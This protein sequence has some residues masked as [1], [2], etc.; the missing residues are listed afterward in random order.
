[1]MT[2]NPQARN[3]LLNKIFIDGKGEGCD[4]EWNTFKSYSFPVRD[5]FVKTL[6]IAYKR[7]VAAVTESVLKI[8]NLYFETDEDNIQLHNRN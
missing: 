1:M 7:E 6:L 5:A 4:K 2:T 3:Y 8:K